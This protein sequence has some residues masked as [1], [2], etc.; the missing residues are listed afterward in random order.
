MPQHSLGPAAAKWHCRRLKGDCFRTCHFDT[1]WDKR[2]GPE[3]VQYFTECVG[4]GF[5][6]EMLSIKYLLKLEQFCDL[7]HG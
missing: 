5:S 1:N 4:Y 6:D 3:D 2:Y 7:F